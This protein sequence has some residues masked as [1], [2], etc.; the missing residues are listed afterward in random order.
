MAG[1]LYGIMLAVLSLG[2]IGGG[3]GSSAPLFLSSAPL[4]AF[5]LV[6]KLFNAPGDVGN[7][8]FFTMLYGT[9]LIWAALG[10][11][12]A[13]S[14]GRMRLSVTRALLLS[15]YAA[16]L[17]LTLL[18]LVA[19]MPANL[20]SARELAAMWGTVYLIGQAASWWRIRNRTHVA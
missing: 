7:T 5:F 9:P 17:A 13:L 2:A 20:W 1:L 16:G 18:A 19:D 10:S 8:T 11:L 3:H 14:G 4:G 6:A 15:Q 12:V